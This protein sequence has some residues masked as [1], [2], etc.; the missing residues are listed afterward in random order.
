MTVASTSCLYVIVVPPHASKS[1]YSHTRIKYTQQLYRRAATFRPLI[2][3]YK[4]SLWWSTIN[5]HSQLILI[6][7]LL[8]LPLLLNWALVV[9]ICFSARTP[10]L[11]WSERLWATTYSKHVLSPLIHLQLELSSTRITA[12]YWLNVKNRNIVL[13]TELF[14]ANSIYF[15][16]A[17][18]VDRRVCGC[19]NAGGVGGRKVRKLATTLALA[20]LSVSP[21]I[22]APN[23]RGNNC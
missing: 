6:S 23:N 2:K 22:V 20:C 10:F 18:N 4:C 5:L 21:T 1:S 19:S 3:L 12:K 7:S 14:C 15:A 16:P 11:S 8:L 9:S 17:C 13:Y